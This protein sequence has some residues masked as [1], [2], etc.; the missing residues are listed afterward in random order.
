MRKALITIFVLF[1]GANCT[2]AHDPTLKSGKGKNTI[3]EYL[4]NAKI[5]TTTKCWQ[6]VF[7]MPNSP[8][9][10]FMPF[11]VTPGYM[12]ITDIII[13]P[14]IEY[15]PVEVE[16]LITWFHELGHSTNHKTRLNRDIPRYAEEIVAE[17]IAIR[18]AQNCDLEH[19]DWIDSAA[20]I[21]IWLDAT[22]KD[23][24]ISTEDY[25]H[26]ATQG[27]NYILGIQP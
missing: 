12:P 17:L 6:I 11:E 7:N 10:V 15:M 25:Q 9:I 13:M 23:A 24:I 21:Q 20:Y 1:V 14:D 5:D 18:L 16:Y 22:P 2:C 8:S 19:R 26:M 4:N 3:V 27:A